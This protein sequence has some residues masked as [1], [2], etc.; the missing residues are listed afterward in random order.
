EDATGDALHALVTD[1]LRTLGINDNLVVFFAGHGASMPQVLEG[2]TVNTGYLIP[3]DAENRGGRVASWIRLDHW[4]ANIARLP[5]R[6]LL[7]IIDACHSGV[8]LDAVRTRDV[9]PAAEDPPS[10]RAPRRSRKVIVSALGG[11]VA[12]DGGPTPGHSLFTG[13]LL[14]ALSHGLRRRGD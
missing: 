13:C 2:A 10:T 5:P 3:A 4:L 1:D 11:E 9:M 7:V 14:E 8:A 12:L 6:P